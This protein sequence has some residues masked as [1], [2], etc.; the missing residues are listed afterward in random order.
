[1][2]DK[3][4]VTYPETETLNP[5]S[6][7]RDQLGTYYS[8]YHNLRKRNDKG[9]RPDSARTKYLVA[10][11]NNNYYYYFIILLLLLIIIINSVKEWE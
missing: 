4:R 9:A 3:E 7:R 6:D 11:Y 2:Y 1:M 5:F 8:R 10:V